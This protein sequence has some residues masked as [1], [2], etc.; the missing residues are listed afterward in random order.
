MDSDGMKKEK[1]VYTHYIGIQTVSRLLDT[2]VYEGE[3]EHPTQK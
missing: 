2:L 1:L 3:L